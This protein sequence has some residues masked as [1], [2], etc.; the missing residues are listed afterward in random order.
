MPCFFC[1]ILKNDDRHA[2]ESKFFS[3]R[4]SEV[5]VSEGNCEIFSKEHKENWFDISTEQW[6]DL[7]E[8][9]KSVKKE[10]EK[11]YQPDGFNVGFNV[12][13]A[14]GQSQKHIHLHIIPRYIGDVEN[15]RGGIRNVI[16]DKGDY[17]KYILDTLPERK[18]Y[19]KE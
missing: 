8:I 4:F 11:Q 3:A 16:P 10:I 13:V 15:P 9:I 12:G 7:Y 5:P 14:G 19:L 1:D 18:K 6:S 2:A 17:Y